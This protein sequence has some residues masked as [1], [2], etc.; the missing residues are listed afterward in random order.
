MNLRSGKGPHPSRVLFIDSSKR[1]KDDYAHRD[2]YNEN[3]KGKVEGSDAAHC[4]DPFVF[5][6]IPTQPP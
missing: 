1:L 5:S 3:D 6:F 4:I 2:Q